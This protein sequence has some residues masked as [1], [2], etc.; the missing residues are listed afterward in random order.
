MIFCAKIYG[1]VV[2]LTRQMQYLLCPAG[3]QNAATDIGLAFPHS[4]HTWVLM[5]NPSNWRPVRVAKSSLVFVSMS[6]L[7]WNTR[8]FFLRRVGDLFQPWGKIQKQNYKHM[9][10]FLKTV[11][12]TL[13]KP[14]DCDCC[15]SNTLSNDTRLKRKETIKDQ[16]RNFRRKT[17][18][19]S[20][21][22]IFCQE[23][24]QSIFQPH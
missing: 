14:Q 11:P 18:H 4:R 10:K 20:L 23:N 17:K 9:I 3:G 1:A 24:R 12:K 15:L 5:S 13:F 7:L 19:E 22:R 21:V 2:L 6:G 16:I 8:L